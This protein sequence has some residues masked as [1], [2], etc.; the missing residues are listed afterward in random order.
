MQGWLIKRCLWLLRPP[1]PRPGVLVGTVPLAAAQND[2]G[3]RSWPTTST[4]VPS[5]F[6]NDPP[7][8][9]SR[10]WGIAVLGQK[11]LDDFWAYHAIDRES[12]LLLEFDQRFLGYPP[13]HSVYRP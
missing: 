13:R 4:G 7:V 5:S 3:V 12:G 9:R 10:P 2:E 11:S 8:E 6:G 1:P